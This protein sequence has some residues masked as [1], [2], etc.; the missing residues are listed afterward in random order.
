MPQ[1]LDNGIQV[2]INGDAY[3][4]A[5][6]LQTMGNKANV[7]TVCASAAAMNALT[8]FSGRMCVRTDLGNELW[9]YTTSWA[10]VQS[11]RQHAEFTGTSDGT[12]TA[13]AAW[14]FNVLT[15]DTS[16]SFND[17]FVTASAL[18]SR[19][20]FTV[21]G[22]YLIHVKVASS[23]NPGISFAS[24]KDTTN[25]YVHADNSNGNGTVWGITVTAGG[26]YIP[27]GGT[28]ILFGLQT[29]NSVT[30]AQLTVRIL[31]TKLSD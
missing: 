18:K 30:A 19:I 7:V 8:T 13:N 14:Q 10:P 23:A 1:L 4:L 6:D 26:V 25:T 17:S 20:T 29:G 3:N 11:T 16:N 15:K 12:T 21:A 31:V 9:T 27:A 5:A 28:D 22:V 24:V 2:P